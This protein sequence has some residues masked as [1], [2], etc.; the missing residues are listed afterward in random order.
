[1]RAAHIEPGAKPAEVAPALAAELVEMARWLQLDGIDVS[2]R[3]GLAAAL[4]R[5]VK[6]NGG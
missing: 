2:R 4:A 1:V 5:A 6:R 3:G